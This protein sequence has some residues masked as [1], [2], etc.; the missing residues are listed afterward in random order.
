MEYICVDIC[1][2]MYIY[3]ET[4]YMCCVYICTHINRQRKKKKKI[5]GQLPSRNLRAEFEVCALMFSWRFRSPLDILSCSFGCLCFDHV[6]LWAFRIWWLV[7]WVQAAYMSFLQ[8]AAPYQWVLDFL[9][10]VSRIK[11]TLQRVTIF[12]SSFKSS[13]GNYFRCP[14]VSPWGP[15]PFGASFL[16]STFL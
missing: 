5:S 15:L 13:L 4:V 11:P 14:S 3:R 10:G 16:F 7:S 9:K 12:L 8:L 2:Y 6:W 1:V